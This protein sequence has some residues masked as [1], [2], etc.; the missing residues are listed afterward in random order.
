VALLVTL[1]VR[2]GTARVASLFLTLGVNLPVIVVIFMAHECIRAV[3]LRRCL[4]PGHRP[5]FRELLRI[6]LLGEAAGTLTR[7][8]PF[9][10]EP[11]RAWML[12]G[13]ALHGPYAYGAVASELI[14]STSMSAVVTILGATLALWTR[15]LRGQIFVLAQVVAWISGTYIVLVVG[16]VVA[17]AYV[18]GRVL[19]VAGAVP[20]VG[21]RLQAN[22]RHVRQVEDFIMQVLR[23]RPALLAQLLALELLAQSALVFEIYW[24][25][26][27]MG[28]AISGSTALLVEALIKAANVI[29]IMGVTE[30]GYALLFNWLGMTAAV[31]FTLSLVRLLRSLAVAAIG[32]GLLAWT[33]RW[34]WWRLTPPAARQSPRTC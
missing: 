25:I 11:T 34:P 9:V 10:A 26:R 15:E 14:A 2:I 18:I 29:Q 28:V 1:L 24:T 4:P 23:N 17:R 12:A 32:L 31:G 8:G 19:R 22:P 30:A 33:G 13:Q 20:V 21:R 5:P 27:S 7:T 16:A 6:R 3:A